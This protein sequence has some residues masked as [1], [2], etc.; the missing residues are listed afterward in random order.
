MLRLNK[1]TKVNPVIYIM[2]AYAPVG[3]AYNISD[4][5]ICVETNSAKVPFC[6]PHSKAIHLSCLTPDTKILP[7]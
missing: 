7:R 5:N 1:N 4:P 6:R 3:I 2:S